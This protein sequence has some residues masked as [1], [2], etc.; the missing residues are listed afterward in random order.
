M[1]EGKLICAIFGSKNF[2]T[3]KKLYNTSIERGSFAYGALYLR[4]AHVGKYVITVKA[5]GITK[6]QNNDAILYEDEEFPLDQMCLYLGHTQAPTSSKR[7]FQTDTSH[8]FR[9]D[10]WFVA[11]NGVITNFNDLK[12]KIKNT[13]H[14]NE[15]DSSIIPALLNYYSQD[16]DDEVIVI[17]EALSALK[18]TFGVWI[19][20]AYSNNTYLARSGSTL[21]ADLLTNDFAS[22]PYKKFISLDEGVIYL[23]T[24][25]GLTTVG[26]FTPNSP[27]FIL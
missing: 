21:Y 2:K 10:H 6:L 27:F 11:H 4:Q 9:C 25:E 19:Y 15:V 22:V 3:Y 13:D 7:V 23:L 12:R 5:E 14:Y 24:Q 26:S 18:G 1:K 20:C 8:P 16:C 17:K